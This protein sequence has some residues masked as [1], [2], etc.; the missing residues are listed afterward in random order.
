MGDP[1]VVSA[2]IGAGATIIA[3]IIAK[4][5]F[6]QLS[7]WI[8]RWRHNIAD[9]KETRWSCTWCFEN[10]ETYVEDTIEIQKWTGG[11]GFRGEGFQTRDVDGQKRTYRYPITGEISPLNVIVLTYK[12]EKYP[13]QGNIGMACLRLQVGAEKMEGYWCGLTSRK[14]DDGR[15]VPD[16]R[17]GTVTCVKA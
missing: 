2:A 5:S 10:G 12:A 16:L 13:T 11:N 7:S 17:H 3:A 1:Q 14:L 4:I 15:K 6:P 9:I 8:F